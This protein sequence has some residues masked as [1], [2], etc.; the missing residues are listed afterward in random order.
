MSRDLITELDLS[1][2]GLEGL[3]LSSFPLM[4]RLSLANNAISCKSLSVSGISK[5]SELFFL[6]LSNNKLKSM[7]RVS[8]IMT[9]LVH[10]V[11]LDI[12]GNACCEKLTRVEIGKKLERLRDPRC[13]FS[14]LNKEELKVEERCQ[15]AL[16]LNVEDIDR[17]RLSFCL[18]Q[19]KADESCT[20]LHLGGCGLFSTSGL[21]SFTNLVALDVS[22]NQMVEWNSFP[23]LRELMY[24]DLRDNTL[25]C[26]LSDLTHSLEHCR[27]LQVLH[28]LRSLKNGTTDKRNEYLVFVFDSLPSVLKLDGHKRVTS[29]VEEEDDGMVD[30]DVNQDQMSRRVSL[31]SLPNASSPFAKPENLHKQARKKSHQR[32]MKD[33]PTTSP[34][35]PLGR[36]SSAK[37]Q[38]SSPLS[39][40]KN[41]RSKPRSASTKGM[42]FRSNTLF[43]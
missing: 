23:A 19:R 9:P 27:K 8:V 2:S 11:Y 21:E 39:S 5:L 7:D 38:R 34:V 20:S 30:M 16:Q 18:Y 40:P 1:F 26:T 10:L 12:T 31:S 25:K 29:G 42:F 14:H 35:P 17:F 33:A 13:C 32:K 3:D 22:S 15:I 43:F 37:G 41:V 24:L 28:I 36:A 6:D 4:K